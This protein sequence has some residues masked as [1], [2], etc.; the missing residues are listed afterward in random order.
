MALSA[1]SGYNERYDITL[2]QPELL[3]KERLC[4]TK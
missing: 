1:E 3:T 4:T 2:R